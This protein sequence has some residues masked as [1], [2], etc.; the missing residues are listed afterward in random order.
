M[1]DLSKILVSLL[2]NQD[3]SIKNAGW[4]KILFG[5]EILFRRKIVIENTVH[6]FQI[7]TGHVKDGNNVRSHEYFI[8]YLGIEEI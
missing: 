4:I 5:W 8:N 1:N 3:N 6:N 7:M 2:V